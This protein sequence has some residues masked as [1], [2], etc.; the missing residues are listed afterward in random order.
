MLWA[1]AELYLAC[2]SG[3]SDSDM[4]TYDSTI[5]GTVDW[6][7]PET[8]EATIEF[9]HDGDGSAEG[10]A[11]AYGPG[12][13]IEYNPAWND[14]VFDEYEGEVNLA[15]RVIEHT[16]YGDIENDWEYFDFT[17][18]NISPTVTYMDPAEGDLLTEAPGQVSIEISETIDP[19][20]L[21]EWD[22]YV[23]DS[24]GNRPGQTLEVTSDTTIEITFTDTLADGNYV[25]T[26]MYV[27]DLAGNSNYE[28]E[29][30]NW[31]VDA[32]PEP[33]NEAPWIIDFGGIEE[34]SAWTFEGQVTDDGCV[35]GLTITFGGLLEGYT[36]TTDSEGYFWLTVDTVNLQDGEVTAQTMDFN[37]ELSNIAI[38]WV[39]LPPV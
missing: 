4:I 22:V 33:Y 1:G 31:E 2:D 18:D 32:E 25:T 8:Y 13:S 36:A 29:I 15:Y 38:F 37:S 27:T 20:N 30:A 21:T 39:S 26:M 34:I 24:E 10:T 19:D 23:E 16:P 5:E 28:A 14:A 6:D 7:S 35:E 12:D 17:L 9:D 3:A 11:M